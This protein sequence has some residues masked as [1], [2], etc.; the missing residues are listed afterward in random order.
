MSEERGSGAPFPTP[1]RGHTAT[2][3][4]EWIDENGHMNMAY[5]V[6]VF[7]GAIDHL[8]AAIGL[9]EPYRQRTRHGTFAAEA[10]LL[11][12]AELMLGDQVEIVTQI[13]GADT[14]RIHLAFEMQRDGQ[15]V[16]QQETMMLHVNL[17]TRRVVPFLPD[18][19]RLIAT[20]AAAHATLPRPDWAGRRLAMPA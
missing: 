17:E 14:K 12:R 11:Y 8:W 15:T 7:D 4:P 9:G 20:A 18:C 2:V 13:L 5:Y 1:Y 6:V 10:H 19:A 3:R 16:A